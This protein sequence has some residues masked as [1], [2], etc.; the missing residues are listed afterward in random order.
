MRRKSSSSVRIYFPKLSKEELV[1]LLKEKVKDLS[2]ELPIKTATLFGSYAA[3]RYTAASDIDVFAVIEGGNKGET[4]HKLYKGLGI[5][6]L[7][8]HLYTV[9]EYEKLKRNSPSFIREV[10][11]KGIPIFEA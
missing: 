8:L 11:S 1:H 6:S 5:D 2:K 4:Y 10:K 7:Q 9:D 3:D